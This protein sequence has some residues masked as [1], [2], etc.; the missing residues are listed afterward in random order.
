MRDIYGVSSKLIKAPV[1]E[2]FGRQSSFTIR[3]KTA[4]RSRQK[5]VAH[6]F[7]PAAIAAV[8]PLV[9][10][11]VQKLLHVLSRRVGEPVDIMEWFRIFALDVVGRF[12]QAHQSGPWYPILT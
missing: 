4:H 6:V 10:D 9:R 8:E 7:A 3:D 1:Y 5:R 11:E 12:L 2:A